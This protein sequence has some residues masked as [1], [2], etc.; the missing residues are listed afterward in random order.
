MGTDVSVTLTE[1]FIFLPQVH[2]FF[3]L[4]PHDSSDGVS[5]VGIHN[6]FPKVIGVLDEFG[7]SVVLMTFDRF[8]RFN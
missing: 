1:L 8:L 4:G 2:L 5:Q 7:R 3:N 6:D